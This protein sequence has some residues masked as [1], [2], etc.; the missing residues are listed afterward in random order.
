M[1]CCVRF[2]AI[3]APVLG[4]TLGTGATR[5]LGGRMRRTSNKGRLGRRL[6]ALGAVLRALSE[7]PLSHTPVIDGESRYGQKR[8]S[9]N[10]LAVPT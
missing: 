3:G 2:G 4:R 5:L 8:G 9:V 10:E 7:A 6:F 1:L